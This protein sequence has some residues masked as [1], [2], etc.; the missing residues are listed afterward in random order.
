MSILGALRVLGIY[1][2]RDMDT[3]VEKSRKGVRKFGEEGTLAQERWQKFGDTAKWVGGLVLETGQMLLEW[4]DQWAEQTRE[5]ERMA[6]AL[7]IASSTL[8]IY[9]NAARRAGVEQGVMNDALLE[10]NKR[11][12]EAATLGTGPLVEVLDRLNLDAE[13]FNDLAVNERF[14]LLT[15]SINRLQNAAERNFLLDESFGGASDQIAGLTT[16]IVSLADAY[17]KAAEAAASDK[18][19]KFQE[20][21]DRISAKV[22]DAQR[23]F[24]IRFADD[25]LEGIE[26]LEIVADNL[27]G[28]LKWIHDL[29][30][31]DKGIA[32]FFNRQRDRYTT[33][34]GEMYNSAATAIGGSFY[35]GDAGVQA[36]NARLEAQL[37]GERDV[38]GNVRRLEEQLATRRE[39]EAL[40]QR[41]LLLEKQRN[42]IEARTRR[43]PEVVLQPSNLQ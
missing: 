21:W 5:I 34:L 17:D 38:E 12:A 4:G 1:D 8:N 2:G 29:F 10:L 37:R 6:D 7:G 42:L 27:I 3:G 14:D 9:N 22:G 39:R 26:S 32:G 33:G 25:A 16:E 31:T 40:M 36:T 18:A 30:N 24:T 13:R 11:S 28:A 15:R 23:D 20:T 41:E 43:R 35:T 19:Q